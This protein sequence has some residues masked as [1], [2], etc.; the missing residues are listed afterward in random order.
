[1]SF[2]KL[3]KPL[4]GDVL[5]QAQHDTGTRTHTSRAQRT[6][7]ARS[8]HITR[9][10]HGMSPLEGL[11]AAN[12]TAARV[13]RREDLGVVRSGALADL[14]AVGGDP[15][16]DIGALRRVSLVVQAGMVVPPSP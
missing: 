13:L 12:S 9:A 16:R 8:A 3:R 11:R 7:H 5:R 6:H 1:M 14:V 4:R 2:D 15:V 10:A